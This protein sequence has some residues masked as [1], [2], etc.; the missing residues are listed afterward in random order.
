MTI[1]CIWAAPACKHGKTVLACTW[2]IC[3]RFS[4]IHAGEKALPCIQEKDWESCSQG[5]YT[6]TRNSLCM[7]MRISVA[8]F[9][10]TCT[11][12]LLLLPHV[13]FPVYMEAS[14]LPHVYKRLSHTHAKMIWRCWQAD[15]GFSFPYT[16]NSRCL[17]MYKGISRFLVACIHGSVTSSACIHFKLQRF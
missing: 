8:D 11:N 6:W 4:C 9:P 1:P 14:T 17:G 12:A 2:G 7:Y 16:W 3:N 13:S 10:Y 5:R 15:A